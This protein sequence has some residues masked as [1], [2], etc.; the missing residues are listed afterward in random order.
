[1]GVFIKERVYWNLIKN[2]LRLTIGTLAFV[3]LI[4]DGIQIFEYLNSNFEKMKDLV[5]VV[6]F[7]II[8]I[9]TTYPLSSRGLATYTGRVPRLD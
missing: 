2:K 3:S 7:V 6:L 1:M 5:K 9:I 8:L 4:A